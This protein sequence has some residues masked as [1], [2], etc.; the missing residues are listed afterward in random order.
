M[1]KART[2]AQVWR[3]RP[4][5]IGIAFTDGTRLFV[6]AENRIEIS[7]TGPDPNRLGSTRAQESELSA[8]PIAVVVIVLA[9]VW[10]IYLIALLFRVAPTMQHLL[11]DLGA[12]LSLPTRT[13]LGAYRWS[14]SVPLLSV[15][16]TIDIMRRRRVHRGHAVAVLI[17]VVGLSCGLHAW[18]ME[19]WFRPMF[20]LIEAVR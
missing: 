1:L 10:Q 8:K 2:V 5:E 7:V 17:I 4:G 13:L 3:H 11:A 6:N 14:P 15:L 9:T 20:Q 18:I 12:E 16:L 19:A